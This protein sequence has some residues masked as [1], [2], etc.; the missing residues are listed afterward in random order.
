MSVGERE[1]GARSA[2]HA[3]LAE[4]SAG[5]HGGSSLDLTRR[6]TANALFCENENR[7]A[8]TLR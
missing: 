5:A 7:R 4:R 1:E 2:K 3:R 8:E 6:P